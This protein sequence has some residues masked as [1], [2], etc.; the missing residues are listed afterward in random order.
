MS[1]ADI[2]RNLDTASEALTDM[3]NDATHRGIP[4]MQ[5]LP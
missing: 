5:Q 2:T 1:G 4:A 3:I